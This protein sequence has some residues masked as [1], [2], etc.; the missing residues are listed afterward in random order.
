MVCEWNPSS[1]SWICP[2]QHWENLPNARQNIIF[3]QDSPVSTCKPTTTHH[4]SSSIAALQLQLWNLFPVFKTP[5]CLNMSSSWVPNSHDNVLHSYLS[6]EQA[7]TCSPYFL[8]QSR[9][10]WTFERR[11]GNKVSD[12]KIESYHII[13]YP[14]MIILVQ[15]S[16]IPSL[17]QWDSL[18]CLHGWNCSILLSDV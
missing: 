11:D 13:R 18:S 17:S 1:G 9:G 15:I 16:S 8:L 2:G 5:C 3:A 14:A 6:L 7:T 4:S 10:L 12:Y